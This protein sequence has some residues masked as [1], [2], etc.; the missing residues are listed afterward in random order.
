[1]LWRRTIYRDEY[2]S[3]HTGMRRF[4]A[5]KSWQIVERPATLAPN[6]A[7][8]PNLVTLDMLGLERLRLPEEQAETM[9]CETCVNR[10]NAPGSRVCSDCD[11][12]FDGPASN[13]AAEPDGTD[14]KET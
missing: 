10:H 1:M 6:E 11:L 13:Y 12:T 14:E 7:P 3:L 8:D 9:A 2:E 5:A 4:A